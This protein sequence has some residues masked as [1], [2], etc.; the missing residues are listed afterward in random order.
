MKR[1]LFSLFIFLFVVNSVKAEGL[2]DLLN[3]TPPAYT[4]VKEDNG[5]G[6]YLSDEIAE[7]PAYIPL[8]AIINEQKENINLYLAGNGGSVTSLNQLL[9]VLRNARAHVHVVVYGD[10]Y[11]AHAMLAIGLNDM[12]A[13]DDNILFLFHTPAMT[14]KDGNVVSSTEACNTIDPKLT[15]RGISARDKCIEYTKAF[16]NQFNVGPLMEI[17][18]VLTKQEFED[19]LK[20]HDIMITYKELKQNKKDNGG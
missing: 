8:F 19:M 13:N 14:L 20:G 1:I 4:V 7:P 12:V 9:S 6:I 2:E 3:K 16:I 11:S 17:K 10:V 18:K 15:D 5:I